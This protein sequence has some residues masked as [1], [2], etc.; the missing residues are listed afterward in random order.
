MSWESMLPLRVISAMISVMK[1]SQ[2]VIN[3]LTT[4][5]PKHPRNDAWD[6][7]MDERDARIKQEAHQ[8]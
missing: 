7:V 8:V 4:G 2:D 5:K 6:R 1:N 3:K